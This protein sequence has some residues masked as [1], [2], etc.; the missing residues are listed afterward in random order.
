MIL[1]DYHL[2]QNIDCKYY[3]PSEF[4]PHGDQPQRTQFLSFLHCNARSLSKNYQ[5][6]DMLLSSLQFK[7]SIIGIS[8][9]WLNNKSP[10][11][12]TVEGYK[13]IRKDRLNGRG[14]GLVLYISDSLSL[15][16]YRSKVNQLSVYV[17]RLTFPGRRISLFV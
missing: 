10:N 17:L 14:G 11:L 1:E 4:N 6:F 9:T 5:N 2:E 13:E 12:F 8:E 3:V 7:C 15:K 16:I